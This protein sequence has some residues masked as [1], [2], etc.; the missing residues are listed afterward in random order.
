MHFVYILYSKS[1]NKYYIGETEDISLRLIWHN[2]KHFQSSYTSNVSD[3]ELYFIIECTDR[4]QARKI[5][6]HIKSMKSR[7][8]IENLKKYK[9]ISEKLLQ[10]YS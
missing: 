2:T 10:K 1:S 9:D 7:T 6:A 5:E 4:S 8:Y 3:W